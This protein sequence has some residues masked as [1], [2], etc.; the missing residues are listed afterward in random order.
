MTTTRRFARDIHYLYPDVIYRFSSQFLAFWVEHQF[1]SAD[2]FDGEKKGVKDA[3]VIPT[4][5]SKKS[6]TFNWI[7]IHAVMWNWDNEEAKKNLNKLLKELSEWRL[8]NPTLWDK[9]LADMP[10][11]LDV[12]KNSGALL[13]G[14]T[15][16]TALK[17][18][19]QL[20]RAVLALYSGYHQNAEINIEG[21]Y[22]R[23]LKKCKDPR[24]RE[25]L[26]GELVKDSAESVTFDW[27]R[28]DEHCC[29]KR[30][31]KLLNW[32]SLH[33]EG[34]Q[35]SARPDENPGATENPLKGLV[36]EILLK[37][38]LLDRHLPGETENLQTSLASH[39]F[40]IIAPIHDMVTGGHGYGGIKGV[41]IL[42]FKDNETRELWINNKYPRMFSATPEL[43]GEITDSAK[44]LAGSIP[45]TPPY[46][47]L[48]HFLKALIYVQDWEEAVVF[49][50]GQFEYGF[51]RETPEGGNFKW[52]WGYAIYA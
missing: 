34:C 45:I 6:R 20:H 39:R 29:D 48:S 33:V 8:N 19:E 1:K 7:S 13:E 43:A 14:F 30:S 22:Y 31:C 27:F 15:S 11:E 21:M 41:I 50:N 2:F 12:Y 47:L 46:D 40:V 16:E 51:K 9:F 5:F 44:I 38:L 35:H 37:E 23:F 17:D 25:F 49:K 36:Y 42:F 24:S 4:F 28:V 52:G 3:Y 26:R 10:Q 18:Y 32:Q